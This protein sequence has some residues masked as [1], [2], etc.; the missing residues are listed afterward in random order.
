[1]SMWD[2]D[3]DDYCRSRK[4]ERH[5][6]IGILTRKGWNSQEY[7]SSMKN[8]LFNWLDQWYTLSIK[9]LPEPATT[10]RNPITQTYRR[11]TRLPGGWRITTSYVD[12]EYLTQVLNNGL[13]FVRIDRSKTDADVTHT[14]LVERILYGD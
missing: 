9:N 11:M 1:M 7:Q 10:R 13:Q 8:D 4:K 6:V 14:E 5:K 3:I 12:N 2:R